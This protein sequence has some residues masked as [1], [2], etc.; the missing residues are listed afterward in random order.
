MVVQS[1]HGGFAQNDTL[2]ID[3]NKRIR[4]SQVNRKVIRKQAPERID[5]QNH[6]IWPSLNPL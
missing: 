3:E 6:L 5:H 1:D 4:R 2:T